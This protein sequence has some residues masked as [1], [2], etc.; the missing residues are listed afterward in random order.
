V[1]LY[2]LENSQSYRGLPIKR[3]QQK[4]G[5]RGLFDMRKD[6]RRS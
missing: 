4:G 6:P 2:N 1:Y 3:H 5:R